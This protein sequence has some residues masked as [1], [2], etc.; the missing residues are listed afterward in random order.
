MFYAV[1]QNASNQIL[2]NYLYCIICYQFEITNIQCLYIYNFEPEI[3]RCRMKDGWSNCGYTSN[4]FYRTNHEVFI[5]CRLCLHNFIF[6]FLMFLHYYLQFKC[7]NIKGCICKFPN[8]FVCAF[9]ISPYPKIYLFEILN[10]FIKPHYKQN[11]YI[12]TFI[13]KSSY[14]NMKTK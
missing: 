2:R 8:L 10:T 11:N 9:H 13:V 7:H 1:D 6:L 5:D 4:R 14:L 3:T 12:L